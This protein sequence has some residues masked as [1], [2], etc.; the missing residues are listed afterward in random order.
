[1]K[2]QLHPCNEVTARQRCVL[3]AAAAAVLALYSLSATAQNLIQNGSFEDPIV[4]GYALFTTGQTIG[5]AWE[6][7][8][9]SGYLDIIGTYG[10]SSVFYPTPAGAQFCYLADNIQYS[11]LR[12]DIATPLTAGFTYE[13]SFLQSTFYPNYGNFLGEVTVELSPAGGAPELTQT[14]SLVGYTDWTLRDLA[15]TPNLSGPYSLR[16]SSTVGQAGN[17]DDV[18]L[19]EAVVPEPAPGGLAFGLTLLGLAGWRR[20]SKP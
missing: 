11:V 16:F 5:G 18:R 19:V 6:V 10:I 8:T 3:P 4:G 12:Q 2:E 9:A 1:M 17:I 14:F 7:E 20:W 13:L 15:F